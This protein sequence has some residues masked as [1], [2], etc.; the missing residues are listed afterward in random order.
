MKVG[1]CGFFGATRPKRV[2]DL[3]SRAAPHVQR[4]PRWR[5]SCARSYGVTGARHVYSD[6]GLAR[7]AEM[8][9]R[10]AH[11]MFN[12]IPRVADAKR[13]LARLSSTQRRRARLTR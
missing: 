5:A 4:P 2:R 3:C 13:F 10:D 8:T 11:V 7:L 12:N 1:S 6:M 9:P